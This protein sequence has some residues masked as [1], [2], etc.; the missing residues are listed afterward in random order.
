[1]TKSINLRL[2][3]IQDEEFRLLKLFDRVCRK[4]NIEY[5][6]DSGTLLGAKRHQNFI[7]WDDD[8]DVAMLRSEYEK[9]MQVPKEEFEENC[10]LCCPEDMP[11]KVFFDFIPKLYSNIVFLWDEYDEEDLFYEK[12]TARVSLDIFVFDDAPASSKKRIL[13]SFVMKMIYGLPLG[14]RY[15][16][17]WKNYKGINKL[18]VFIL[19]NIGKM[20]KKKTILNLFHK[21]AQKFNGKNSN[22][23]W[24]RYYTFSYMNMLFD[25]KWFTETTELPIRDYYFKVPKG[26]HEI[27]TKIYG[28]YMQLPPKEKQVSKHIKR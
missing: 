7:P 5:F 16:L 12:N 28:D 27:L 19:S 4:Y 10:F 17:H 3:E 25:K 23:V 24:S 15:K 9:L 21:N 8:A 6:L 18:Y 13:N 14:R 20:L 22:L 11:E 1:M 2:E 26:Y